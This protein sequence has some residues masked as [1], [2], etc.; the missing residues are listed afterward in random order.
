M[1]DGESRRNRADAELVRPTV[2]HD[3]PTGDLKLTVAVYERSS[4]EP[5]VV[6]E[7]NLSKETI[8]CRRD[9]TFTWP[10]VPP[11]R[12]IDATLF[13]GHRKLILSVLATCRQLRQVASLYR[14]SLG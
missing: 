7:S 4:P 11:T 14:I 8:S 6:S 9:G 5:A 2:R 10:V 13:A 1:I 12:A 3:W